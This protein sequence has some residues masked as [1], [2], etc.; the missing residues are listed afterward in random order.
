MTTPLPVNQAEQPASA[1]PIFILGNGRSGTTLMRFMLNAHPEIYISEEVCYHFWLRSHYGSFKRRLYLFFH[2][3]SFAWLRLDPHEVLAQLPAQ[4]QAAHGP[5]IYLRVLQCKAAQYG[6]PRYGEKGPLL[7]E[8]LDQLLRDY[9][10]ARIISMVRDPRAVVYSHFTMPWSTSSFIAANLMVRMNMR[11]IEKHAGR[12]LSVKLEDLLADP[13]Q[14]LERVLEHVG[15]AWSEQVLRHTE[16]LPE[17][18][19]IPFPWLMEA[20]RR[21]KQKA[22]RWQDDMPAAWVRLT[23]RINRPILLRHAYTPMPLA[24]EPGVLAMIWAVISDLPQLLFTAGSFVWLLLRFILTPKTDTRAFQKL[25]HDLNPWAW[26][27]QPD[28]ERELP[29]PPAVRSPEQL[30]RD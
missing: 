25:M 21:P 3:F 24:R 19:G 22:L 30:L 6:K 5:L 13:R 29:T 17:N 28:W 11:R 23:E 7:T 12:V 26:R 27:R 14:T 9:P 2:S 20:S 16:H 10:D 8:D 4:L 18:D 1:A 15:V